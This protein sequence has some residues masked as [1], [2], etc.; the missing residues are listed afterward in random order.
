MTQRINLPEKLFDKT[1]Y[2]IYQDEHFTVT[3]MQYDTGVAGLKIS[4]S[5]GYI[6]L[7]PFQ[8]FMIWDAVFDQLSLKMTSVFD[9]PY[10]GTQ[11]T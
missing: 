3:T 8:G 5:R 10:L 9:K 1:P 6:V 4:N 7:L 2:N 11:V